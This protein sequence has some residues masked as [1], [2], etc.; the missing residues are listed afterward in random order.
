MH[1]IDTIK[2]MVIIG[3]VLEH[4]LNGKQ[5]KTKHKQEEQSPEVVQVEIVVAVVPVDQSPQK[6]R[7]SLDTTKIGTPT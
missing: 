5:Q 6:I 2:R 7:I 4:E 3:L 1:W